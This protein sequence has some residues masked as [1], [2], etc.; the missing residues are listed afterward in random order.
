MC[1]PTSRI[2]A[3]FSPLDMH[4][5][6]SHLASPQKKHLAPPPFPAH[7]ALNAASPEPLE[8]HDPLNHYKLMKQPKD[9]HLKY[10]PANHTTSN[11]YKIQNL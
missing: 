6:P 10:Q 5:H 2:T 7:P 8:A 1:N 3:P 9:W 11:T 4:P